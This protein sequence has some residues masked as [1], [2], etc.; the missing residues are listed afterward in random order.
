MKGTCEIKELAGLLR[1]GGLTTARSGGSDCQGPR[2]AAKRGNDGAE[3]R[4][5]GNG[6]EPSMPVDAWSLGKMPKCLGEIASAGVDGPRWEYTE[7]GP[8]C[9]E[10]RERVI[11][12][13]LLKC[14]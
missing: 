10:N 7:H 8:S 4:T 11:D 1:R 6:W 12:T 2:D 13:Y 3:S 14:G 5:N 9:S